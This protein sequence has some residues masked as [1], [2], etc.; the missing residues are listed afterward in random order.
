MT[1]TAFRA[2]RVARVPRPSG[3]FNI[4]PEQA[5]VQMAKLA[6]NDGIHVRR[7]AA[8]SAVEP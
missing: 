8:S 5:V 2:A 1:C 3:L 6:E 4:N 7:F